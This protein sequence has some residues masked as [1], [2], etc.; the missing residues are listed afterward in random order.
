ME[1]NFNNQLNSIRQLVKS[2]GPWNSQKFGFC[3]DF[4]IFNFFFI[5]TLHWYSFHQFFQIQ[6]LEF[7]WFPLLQFLMIS[8]NFLT[9]QLYTPSIFGD[10]PFFLK[11][12]VL[13]HEAWSEFL[14]ILCMCW[15]GYKG[16]GETPVFIK[17]KRFS[18]YSRC[19]I[20]FIETGHNT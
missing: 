1:A 20:D 5:W 3:I 12:A 18:S 8:Y 4:Q 6:N 13:K 10:F 9:L 7:L 14:E 11:N 19:F 2:Y 15:Y 16:C 17:K